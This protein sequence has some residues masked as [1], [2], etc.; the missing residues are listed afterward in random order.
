MQNSGYDRALI[1]PVMF[2]T[3]GTYIACGG[4]FTNDVT[5]TTDYG[6]DFPCQIFRG[7][8]GPLQSWVLHPNMSL[9][10][11]RNSSGFSYYHSKYVLFSTFSLSIIQWFSFE[12]Q[13]SPVYVVNCHFSRHP[14]RC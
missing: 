6:L 14:N 4:V 13:Q 3:N 5:D 8:Y 7:D 2:E 9:N 11:I 12:N 10:E 1:N